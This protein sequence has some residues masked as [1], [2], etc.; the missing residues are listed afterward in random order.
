MSE[1]AAN[2]TPANDDLFERMKALPV[3]DLKQM[4]LIVEL[5]LKAQEAEAAESAHPEPAPARTWGAPG[6]QAAH[7][8][9]EQKVAA[10]SEDEVFLVHCDDDL[11]EVEKLS[12]YII[13]HQALHFGFKRSTLEGQGEGEMIGY[14]W[15]ETTK[16]IMAALPMLDAQAIVD[17]AKDMRKE[18]YQ[19]RGSS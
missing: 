4:Q 11:T 18:D 15:H 1:A 9:A 16:A 19:G 10:L 17:M 7:E 12:L 8:A 3:S 2:T 5:L 6:V 14:L 13:G